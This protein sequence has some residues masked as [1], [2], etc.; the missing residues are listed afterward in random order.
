VSFSV[1]TALAALGR[2]AH[3]TGDDDAVFVGEGGTFLDGR[4]LRR[5]YLTAI[6][7]AGL[8]P[9]RS[10]TYATPSVRG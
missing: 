3:W 6:K 7:R 10:T 5:R 9:L 1:A 4:A 2:R 8:R